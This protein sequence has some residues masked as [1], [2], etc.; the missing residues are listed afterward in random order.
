MEQ[1]CGQPGGDDNPERASSAPDGDA[2]DA[3][4]AAVR[5]FP[6]PGLALADCAAMLGRAGTVRA[7]TRELRAILRGVHRGATCDGR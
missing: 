7:I 3:A 1:R 4:G 2:G 6:V 5:A